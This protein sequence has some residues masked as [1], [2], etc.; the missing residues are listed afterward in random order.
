MNSKPIRIFYGWAAAALAAFALRS[1]ADRLLSN[2]RVGTRVP[3]TW[4]TKV[5]EVGPTLWRGP[6]PA[7]NEAYEELSAAGA[8]TVVDLRSEVDSVSIRNEASSSGLTVKHIPIDNTRAPTLADL[9][10]FEGVMAESSGPVYVHCE[11]GEGRTGSIV[12]AHQVRTGRGRAV[13]IADALT[14][15]SLAFSQMVYV[16]SAGALPPLIALTEWLLDRPTAALFGLKAL[17]APQSNETR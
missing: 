10:R 4:S 1:L 17:R 5:L 2:R 3:Q 6:A 8:R 13:V 14:V 12:G 11:A 15:G 7:G 9:E 16:V